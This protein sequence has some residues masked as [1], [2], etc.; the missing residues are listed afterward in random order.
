ME[1]KDIENNSEFQDFEEQEEKLTQQDAVFDDEIKDTPLEEEFGESFETMQEDLPQKSF[2]EEY[3]DVFSQSDYPIK[4]EQI[5]I[6]DTLND[7]FIAL[8]KFEKINLKRYLDY[9]K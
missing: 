7:N 4:E 3:A 1:E 6:K 9:I 8:N 5:D 2:E